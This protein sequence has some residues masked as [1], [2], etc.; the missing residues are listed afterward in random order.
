MKIL[1]NEH[2]DYIV[3]TTTKTFIQLMYRIMPCLNQII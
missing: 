3:I 2:E 1:S